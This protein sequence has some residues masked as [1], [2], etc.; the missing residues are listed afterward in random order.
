MK[1]NTDYALVTGASSGLG[2]SY[3]LELAK[4]GI[5][6]LLVSRENEG[7]PRLCK[8]IKKSY[9]VDVYYFETDLTIMSKLKKM[10]TWVNQ[11]F[12][13]NILINNAGIGGTVEFEKSKVS[14]LDDTIL[15]NIR[16]LSYL[17]HQLLQ[18]LKSSNNN[19]FIL[20]VSSMAAFCP[21][22]FK[23][24]YPATK[25]FIQHFT[26]GLNYELKKTNVSVSA[27]FPGPMETNKKV[28]ARIKK[29]GF[30]AKLSLQN[31][32]EVAKISLNKLFN[33]KSFI[34]VGLLNKLNWI[35]LKI[36]PISI[37]IPLLS[38]TMKRELRNNHIKLGK[39]INI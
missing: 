19:S 30:L 16:A 38:S 9:K 32:D 7:L 6:L 24:V 12:K 39:A 27:V 29:Q 23:S 4:R 13:I 17:T 15:L 11:N 3:A 37:T 8:S 34:I 26:Q 33:E 25:K 2:K 18:N 20:N 22:S 1:T 31:P 35:L 21:M 5:P 14:F 36:I 28:T 10:V